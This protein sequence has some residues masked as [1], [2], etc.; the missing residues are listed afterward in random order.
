MK[1]PTEPAA[2]QHPKSSQYVTNVSETLRKID[3][4]PSCPNCEGE[5]A[6]QVPVDLVEEESMESFPASDPPAYSRP[7]RPEPRRPGQ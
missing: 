7:D 5:K 1:N 2:E 6:K 4:G 3:S